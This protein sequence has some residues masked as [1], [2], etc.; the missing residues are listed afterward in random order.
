[1]WNVRALLHDYER[2]IVMRIT[3]GLTRTVVLAAAVTAVAAMSGAPAVAQS[4]TY[5]Y[6]CAWK[7]ANAGGNR[8]QF[9]GNNNN[10]ALFVG[11]AGTTCDN[12]ASSFLNNGATSHF[13]YYEGT[14]QTLARDCVLKGQ[15]Q[16]T[17]SSAMNDR[18][19]SNLWFSPPTPC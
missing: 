12:M 4:C 18:T 17:I 10:W 11:T 16:P 7:D 6:T 3:L 13:R 8:C 5:E 2:Q 15:Y 19:S 1:M 14:S 9:K